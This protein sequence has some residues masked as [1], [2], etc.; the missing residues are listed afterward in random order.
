MSVAQQRA[1]K[2]GEVGTNGEWYEGGKFLPTT[3]KPKGKKAKRGSGKQQVAPYIWEVPLSD[4]H[5]A[6]FGKIVGTYAAYIDR[7]N[8]DA[9]IEPFAPA[10]VHYGN[11]FRGNAINDL[12]EAYN[13]GERW[14]VAKHKRE[15]R[16][17]S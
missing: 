15:T 4:E 16:D 14:A 10:I 8:P 11:D 7:S 9:G 6:I 17:D 1:K 12:C 2:G 3:E 5:F 13:N